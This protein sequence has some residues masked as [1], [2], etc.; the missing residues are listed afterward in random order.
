MILSDNQARTNS[1]CWRKSRSEPRP[2]GSAQTLTM[3]RDD[4]TAAGGRSSAEVDPRHSP[5]ERGLS[6]SAPRAISRCRVADN[7]VGGSWGARRADSDHSRDCCGDSSAC[8]RGAWP[9]VQVRSRG[10]GC[11]RGWREARRAGSSFPIARKAQGSCELRR[12]AYGRSATPR[13]ARSFGSGCGDLGI[14]VVSPP[15]EQP[16]A[17]QSRM[18]L[19]STR[20][21]ARDFSNRVD[22][23]RSTNM[24]RRIQLYEACGRPALSGLRATTNGGDRGHPRALLRVP[25]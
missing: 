14:R 6:P 21:I 1:L 13:P 8:Q 15:G 4:G 3:A 2:P 22:H 19:A 17:L 7:D 20:T 23:H 18:G 25:A 16:H 9:L 11:R 10:V 24:G 12:N 5:G